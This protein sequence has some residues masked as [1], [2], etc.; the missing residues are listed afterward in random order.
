MNFPPAIFRQST[1][2][3]CCDEKFMLPLQTY[4]H[5]YTQRNANLTSVFINAFKGFLGIFFFTYINFFLFS[6]CFWFCRLYVPQTHI[7][8]ARTY[9]HNFCYSHMCTCTNKKGFLCNYHFKNCLH[10]PYFFPLPYHIHRTLDCCF[11]WIASCNENCL[12]FLVMERDEKEDGKERDSLKIQIS[13]TEFFL[14]YFNFLV[15]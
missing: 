9:T 6:Y 2:L 7:I 5:T 14:F 1:S 15:H 4:L 10:A 11:F 3:K 13:I 8:Q 12:V